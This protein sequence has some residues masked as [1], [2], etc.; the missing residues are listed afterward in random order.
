MLC[1]FV[2]AKIVFYVQKFLIP[3]QENIFGTIIKWN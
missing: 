3:L 2:T 1:V